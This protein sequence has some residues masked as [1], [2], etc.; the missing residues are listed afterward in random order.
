MARKQSRI[1]KAIPPLK[2][3]DFTVIR[4]I[5]PVLANRLQKSGIHTYHELASMSPVKLAARIPNLS[6]S[7]IIQQDWIGQA[8][9]LSTN[10]AG[11][12][13]HKKVPAS[14]PI[15]QSYENFTIEFLLD[16]KKEARRTRVVHIQSGDADTWTGWEAEK[17][18]DFLLRHTGLHT[19]PAR[20]IRKKTGSAQ[21]NDMQ[22]AGHTPEHKEV[23]SA[24][25]LPAAPVIMKPDNS[26]A[27]PADKVARSAEMV[28]AA[29]PLGLRDLIMTLPDS[30]VPIFFLRQGHPFF[31]QLTIDHGKLIPPG[32]TPPNC[33]ATIF[34]KQV[35]GTCEFAEETSYMLSP[36]E[37]TSLKIAGPK[38]SAGI[39]RL[40]TYV[41]IAPYQGSSERTACLKGNLLEVY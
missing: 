26:E 40:S 38:L 25:P 11:I 34:Y 12:K 20:L 37:S 16:E 39:Y 32:N 4:G 29:A 23:I 17:L 8:S 30:D 31:V 19:L 27:L 13:V 6:T 14:S 35:G 41:K 15:R 21:T 18:N 33:K 5:G 10:K 1:P 3:D 2:A 24:D 22:L 28:E 7:Q 9:K 36:S